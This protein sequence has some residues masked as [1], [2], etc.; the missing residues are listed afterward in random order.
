MK[1]HTS[2][3]KNSIKQFG[4]QL[5]SKI[6]YQLNGGTI[7]LG[8][9]VLNSITPNFKSNI[10][11]SAMK[12]LVIDSNID[13][14]VGTIL[15]YEFGVLVDDEYEYINFGNYIVKTSE[16]KED[17]NSY[18]I[19]CY[20]FMLRAMNDYNGL[21]TASFPLTVKQYINALC[22]DLSISFANNNDNF[23]NSE[24][25]IPSDLYKDLGYTYRDIFDELAQVTAST[26][27]INENNEL[28]VRYINETNDSIDEEYL[29][30]ININ[31][32]EKYGP[33]NS[34]VLSRAGGSD[35]IY[36]N[37]PQSIIENGLCE[38]KIND[39]QIMNFNDRGDYLPDILNKLKGLEYY[40]NDFSSTGVCYYDLC[41]KYDVIIGD[42]IYH[43]IMFN[44]EIN[45]T[46]GLEEN[47]Y[48]E[49]PEESETDYS[50]SDKTDRKINQAYL[51]VDK[52]NSTI[53]G[54]VSDVNGQNKKIAQM[55]MSVDEINQKISEVTNITVAAED[56]DASV[57]LEG[58]NESEPIQIKIHPIIENISYLYPSS[59]LYPSS[60][61]YPK[62]RI[63]RFTRR[64][65]EERARRI[66]I[67]DY[68]LPYDLLYYNQDIYDEFYLD[69]DSQ[70]CHVIKR[71]MYNLDGTVEPLGTEEIIN[72]PYP[73]IDLKYGDYTVSLLGYNQAYLY[74]RLMAS[75]IYTTQFA[76][77]V[78][79]STSIKSTAKSIS[80]TANNG[81][82][83]SGLV[84]R[85]YNEDGTLLN[86][87]DANITMSGLVKF[88]DLSGE[89]STTIDGSNITTGVIKSN[90]YAENIS[91]TSIN[92][93]NG[94]IDTKNF[95]VSAVGDITASSGIIGGWSMSP[96]ALSKT[97]GNYNLELRSDRSAN[98]PAL[99]VYD[100]V[101]R[102]YNWYVRP[103]GYM[104]ARIGKFEGEVS[105]GSINIGSNTHYLRMGSDWLRNPE[106][107]G[108][109]ITG[110]GGLDMGGNGI[111]NLSTVNLNGGGT[112]QTSTM[113]V[114]TKF[115]A[116]SNY[117]EWYR[118]ALSF[119]N[120]IYIGYS[121][122]G[123]Y[124]Q[125]FN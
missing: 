18:E 5:D 60:N 39:N 99:L 57:E 106:V 7:E 41:D 20:D 58:V 120:G 74:V 91:G 56:T 52:Q 45:I 93:I 96:V 17:T 97:V 10:L 4:R 8:A 76:T 75:N 70:T 98:Q 71:C 113:Y 9:E 48:T 108:L 23:A 63:L 123:P 38:I 55:Q 42:K 34:I 54:L 64:Y 43:C 65:D 117:V 125:Y 122:E 112:G 85:L 73:K 66:E 102:S 72:I 121:E 32:G 15:K 116:G 35:N 47:I 6:T 105:G 53:T 30:D 110:G 50:K 37:D 40:I 67:I 44:D 46:Q 84:I 111:N 49:A 89:N 107:S 124:R 86:E 1:A 11:K 81:Y 12:E 92:L 2:N 118:G 79:L 77:K 24:R 68:E 31:F 25:V 119:K 87:A 21:Q 88:T 16:K 103:D 13:I 80:L 59:S 69:Y 27:C 78:E 51:I 62:L 19:T 3:F 26:I 115:S 22:N 28:E 109:T 114:T 33:V 61:I 95:K 101:N 82:S 94:T 104:Y 90:N 36:L 29:K 100:N 14:P 83:S